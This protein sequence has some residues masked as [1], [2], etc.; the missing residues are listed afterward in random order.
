[1]NA[2]AA[3]TRHVLFLN[4]RDTRNPEGGGS[5]VYV[6]R[7]A[8][9]LVRR[10]HQATLLCATHTE[11]PAEET[12]TDGVRV[13]RRGGRHTV[14]LRAALVYLAGALGLGA[15]SRRH[16][17]RPDLIVDVGN[18]LPFLSALYARRPVIALV[19][20]V[21][22]EQW[23]VVLGRWLAR[24]GWWV[25][26]WLAPRVYRRC[27]YV[28][29]SA[30]TRDELATLGI[31]P[32]RVAIV[33]NGTPDMTVGP[34]PRSPEPSLVVLGRLVPHKQVEVALQVIAA[35]SGELPGLTLTVAG[36][37]WWE[38]QLRQFAADLGVTD[39]VRF[40][41]FVADADKRELLASAWVALTPSLKEGWGLTI[42]EAGA[43][44]TPTVA[45]RGA[46]GVEEALVDGE[47][48]L[49]AEDL[50]DFVAKV[51][52][53]LTD[54]AHRATI[55]AAARA[56]AA[57]FTWPVSGEKFAALVTRAA[58]APAASPAKQMEQ[59]YLVP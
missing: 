22:R 15:L 38:P 44:G 55:G 36:Q 52:L 45:F 57:R 39:R 51:R 58:N 9:E 1:M 29:V 35:L 10:G 37:G 3:A 12:T 19:H 34:V 4:W 20:H 30:A 24:F 48:G 32:A 41:G 8:G 5:E 42:V 21:H 2:P 43:V 26:S 54:D 46:G 47:T 14:Y 33:H 13:L 17:G 56:H 40:T 59:S 50:D 49:L 27:Q 18:G 7:I 6:E 23:P 16:G 53:L 11:G 28:T 25:E 31:D